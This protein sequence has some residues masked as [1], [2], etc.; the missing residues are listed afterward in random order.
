MYSPALGRF[1]SRDPMPPAGEP[2]VLHDN[3][4]F[5]QRLTRMRNLYGYAE[6]N[7]V[8]WV[9]PSGNASM[10][11]TCTYV[12]GKVNEFNTWYNGA[13]R[14]MSWLANL[15]NCPC[16]LPRGCY[17]PRFKNP[18]PTI[19]AFSPPLGFHPGASNCLRSRAA[20]QSGA[21]QQCCYDSSGK[22]ITHGPGAGTPDSVQPGF[23]WTGHYQSDVAPFTLAKWIDENGAG[24]GYGGF[25]NKYLLARP[26]NSGSGCLPNP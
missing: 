9:D 10:P 1:I 17:N 5:G 20:N 15:P 12:K 13:I 25:V 21:A 24:C 8:N 23:P 4:W 19:W 14:N 16:I 11:I 22:L 3:N 18:D 6:N 2:V 26:P 7:P